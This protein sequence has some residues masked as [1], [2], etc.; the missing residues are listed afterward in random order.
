[1]STPVLKSL[2]ESRAKNVNLASLEDILPLLSQPALWSSLHHT[3]TSPLGPDLESF[4]FRQPVVRKS[5]WA[6]V[7]SLLKN[8][9]AQLRQEKLLGVVS[10]AILRSAWVEPDAGVRGL[11]WAPLLGFL[12]GVSSLLVELLDTNHFH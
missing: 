10:T 8:W 1:M 6:L 7:Q 3:E 2:A 11:M 4:G 9:K 5:A 12:K